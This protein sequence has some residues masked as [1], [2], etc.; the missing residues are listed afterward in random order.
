M[1]GPRPPVPPPLP[2]EKAGAGVRRCSPDRSR[3]S[4]RPRPGQGGEWRPEAT[5]GAAETLCASLPGAAR[6]QDRSSGGLIRTILRG[7]A[8]RNSQRWGQPLPNAR[9]DPARATAPLTRATA[10]PSDPAPAWDLNAARRARREPTIGRFE[11]AP[12]RRR[13]RCILGAGGGAARRRSAAR[14]RNASA[15]RRAEQGGASARLLWWVRR[16]P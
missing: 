1:S 8:Q 11:G 7:R 2:P 15:G 13:A 10:T 5:G 9:G 6:P 12:Q 16:A 3:A 14:V 4:G